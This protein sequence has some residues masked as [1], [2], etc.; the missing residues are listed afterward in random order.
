[1]ESVKHRRRIAQPDE[2]PE[3]GA[4]PLLFKSLSLFLHIVQ[5]DF[6]FWILNL[7]ISRNIYNQ[8]CMNNIVGIQQLDWK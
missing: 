2:S 4:C 3:E 1:M 8:A 7:C 6:E 5:A